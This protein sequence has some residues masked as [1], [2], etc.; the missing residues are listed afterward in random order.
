[1]KRKII[2]PFFNTQQYFLFLDVNWR[3]TSTYDF[4]VD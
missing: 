2:R 3:P 4:D 1:M